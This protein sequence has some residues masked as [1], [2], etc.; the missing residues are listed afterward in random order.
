MYR[1]RES[2]EADGTMPSGYRSGDGKRSTRRPYASRDTPRQRLA[3]TPGA[4]RG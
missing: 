1:Q 4:F 2:N 3:D